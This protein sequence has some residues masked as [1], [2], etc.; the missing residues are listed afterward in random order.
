[1]HREQA[2]LGAVTEQGEQERQPD[3]GARQLRGVLDQRGDG[4]VVVLAQDHRT[5]EVGEHR[6]QQG[7]AQARAGDQHVL[8]GRLGGAVALLGWPSFYRD[9]QGRDDRGD[10]DRDPQQGQAAH[11]RG[12]QHGPGEQVEPG[13]KAPDVAVA[14]P[15]VLDVAD[16]VDADGGVQETGGEQEDHAEGVDPQVGEVAQI[17]VGR[18]RDERED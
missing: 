13:V 12:G 10:L 1:V 17:V 4:Q 11:Q 16:R 5:G 8:P 15:M 14:A 18:V 7:Q 6:G 9:Q 3:R 2:D